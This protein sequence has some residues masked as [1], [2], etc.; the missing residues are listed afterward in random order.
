M[1]AVTV[2]RLDGTLLCVG[3]DNGM[4][5]PGYDTALSTKQ[6]ET[7]YEAIVAEWYQQPVDETER[8]RAKRQLTSAKTVT[9]LALLLEKLL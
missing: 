7:D 6:V 4:Y 5:N 8:V 3:P 1:N 9:D 2:R